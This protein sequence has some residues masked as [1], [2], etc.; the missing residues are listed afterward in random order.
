MKKMNRRTVLTAALGACAATAGLG[1]A[2]WQQRNSPPGIHGSDLPW[3]HTRF[4]RP[5]GGDLA[6]NDFKGQHV[7]LN[8]WATWCPPCVKEMPMLDTFAQA[9]RARGWQVVGLALDRPAAIQAF[10]KRVP[11]SF[12]VGIAG[13]EALDLSV[14]LGN[15]QSQLPFSALWD[16]A[17]RLT[18]TRLGALTEED[19]RAWASL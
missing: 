2:W 11:V 12:P 7:L 17:T 8:F 10:L 9:Q 13:V 19:L 14:A 15:T 5:E 1:L 6:L 4:E 18:A 3:W 16:P